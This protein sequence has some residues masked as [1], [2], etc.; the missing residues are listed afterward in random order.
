MVWCDG[1]VEF[2]AADGIAVDSG[3]VEVVDDVK[4]VDGWV[5]VCCCDEG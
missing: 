3:I 4:E 5:V 1:D 2:A